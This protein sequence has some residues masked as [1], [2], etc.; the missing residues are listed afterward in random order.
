M[1]PN[2]TG[3]GMPPFWRAQ[4]GAEP[5]TPTLTVH[6]HAMEARALLGSATPADAKWPCPMRSACSSAAIPIVT[7]NGSATSKAE[8]AA[9]FGHCYR[10]VRKARTAM[11]YAAQRASGAHAASAVIS[12]SPC[13]WRTL[14][15]RSARPSRRAMQRSAPCPS[16]LP[17]CPH[18]RRQLSGRARVPR[19][20][21][22]VCPV[23]AS[24][25]AARQVG[26]ST[27]ASHYCYRR[28]AATQSAC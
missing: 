28:C 6:F 12:S 11:S 14:I 23:A 25:R 24:D 7:R 5:R 27:A 4:P 18:A 1:P 3:S 21:R 8:L 22:C 20:G 15:C 13:S 9:E 26:V 19:A 2:S 16:R 17:R 10:D